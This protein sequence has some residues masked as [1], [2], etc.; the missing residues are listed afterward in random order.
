MKPRQ[1]FAYADVCV[2]VCGKRA[3]KKKNNIYNMDV[4]IVCTQ[5]EA[6]EIRLSKPSACAYINNLS[7]S[8][9]LR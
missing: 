7:L 6:K 5:C 8:T 9:R 3:R 1:V 4:Y 2:C